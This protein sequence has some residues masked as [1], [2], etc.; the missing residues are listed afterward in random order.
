MGGIFTVDRDA[1]TIRTA[2]GNLVTG[3]LWVVTDTSPSQMDMRHTDGVLWEAIYEVSGN[4][5]RLTYVA[6]TDGASRPTSF[7]TD[8]ERNATKID[9]ERRTR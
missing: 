8:A 3:R 1:F 9:L 2:T 4:T 7:A 6:I 5:L